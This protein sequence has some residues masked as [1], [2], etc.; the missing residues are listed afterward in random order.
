GFCP[1]VDSAVLDAMRQGYISA[2][3]IMPC[4]ASFAQLAEVLH[5]HNIR[6]IGWHVTL[7]E[8]SQKAA[9]GEHGPLV[10][11]KGF[12]RERRPTEEA[13]STSGMEIRRWLYRELDSQLSL[14]L[15]AGFEILHICGHRHFHLLPLVREV[16]HEIWRERG[17]RPPI[18]R[19]CDVRLSQLAFSRAYPMI[20]KHAEKA[21]E[22]YTKIGWP[23]SITIGFGWGES[24][25]WPHLEAELDEAVSLAESRGSVSA[26]E[27]MLHLARYGPNDKKLSMNRDAEYESYSEICRQGVLT[28]KGLFPLMFSDA[29]GF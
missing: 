21:E 10:D 19:G 20:I 17:F 2:P 18:V 5:E 4:G 22:F 26:I 3:S 13:L 29:G 1:N 24:P 8:P 16:L 14:L 15:S 28:R 12:F 11:E 6:A 9:S 25:T 23:F 27:L 7:G